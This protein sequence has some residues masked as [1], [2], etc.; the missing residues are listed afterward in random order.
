MP[1]NNCAAC[2]VLRYDFR[3]K[4]IDAFAEVVQRE[5]KLDMQTWLPHHKNHVLPRRQQDKY[6]Q[7]STY[8]L[9]TGNSDKT[10]K[11]EVLL[12]MRLLTFCCKD[13]LTSAECWLAASHVSTRPSTVYPSAVF[14]P[15]GIMQGSCSLLNLITW[16]RQWLQARSIQTLTVR[17]LRADARDP[18]PPVSTFALYLPDKAS[19]C[20]CHPGR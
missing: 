13:C 4:T 18:A 3:Q 19:P 14:P 17:F 6:K 5:L 2:Y 1:F 9:H 11:E 20:W 8:P 16:A 12:Q 15:A 10:C 7:G